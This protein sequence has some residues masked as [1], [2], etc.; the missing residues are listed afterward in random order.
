[1]FNENGEKG[2]ITSRK[3]RVINMDYYT[4]HSHD[5]SSQVTKVM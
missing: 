5:L 2:Q 3:T 1:M 4:V